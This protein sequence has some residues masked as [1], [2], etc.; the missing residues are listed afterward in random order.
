MFFC[1][2]GANTLGHIVDTFNLKTIGVGHCWYR[3]ILKAECTVTHLAVEMHVA[4]VI[5]LTMGM[6]QLIAYPLAAVI[7]LMQQMVFLEKHQGTE[8]AGL[9]NGINLV[10]QFRHGDGTVNIGQCIQDQKPVGGGLDSMLVQYT[11]QFLHFLVKVF[12]DTQK[13]PSD[14][15]VFV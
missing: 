3:Y 11:L 15:A 12:K 5:N 4:V 7:N 13:E 10:L 9:V 8:Y 1:A 6:A 14:F 2:L